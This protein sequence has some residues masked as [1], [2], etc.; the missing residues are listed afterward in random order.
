[1]Q[2]FDGLQE[3]VEHELEVFVAPCAAGAACDHGRTHAVVSA[4]G[5]DARDSAAGRTPSTTFGQESWRHVQMA[6]IRVVRLFRR[7]GPAMTVTRATRRG[8]QGSGWLVGWAAILSVAVIA[9]PFRLASAWPGGGYAD[10][11]ELAAAVR[12]G[13]LDLWASG[14]AGV[15]PEL[16]R[17]V[18][19]WLRFHLAKAAL[20]GVLLAVLVVLARRV[21]GAAAPVRRRVARWAGAAV[22]SAV[23]VLALLVAVANIQGVVAPLSSVLG[24]L[25][26]RAPDAELASTV[27]TAREALAAGART[28]ATDLLLRDF[29]SYHV[30]M[31]MLGALVVF[32]LVT[33]FMRLRDVR[34]HPVAGTPVRTLGT[35]AAATLLVLLAAFF[36]LVAAANAATAAK[37]VP[38][39][40]GFLAGSL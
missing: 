31:A 4:P 24:L 7:A 25:P 27:R 17:A 34:L 16:A 22:W 12:S 29:T 8:G 33:I 40:I 5:S 18:E 23:A 36:A 1:M 28:P 39:L 10:R 21:W 26:L 2:P 19:F 32:A 6:Q 37:P 30:V 35:G 13:F 9:A 11:A 14:R 15:S 3:Q 20:A 38:A